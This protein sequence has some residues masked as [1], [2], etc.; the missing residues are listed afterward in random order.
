ME[1][2]N[3]PQGFLPLHTLSIICHFLCNLC[4]INWTELNST[5]DYTINT[6][7]LWNNSNTKTLFIKYISCKIIQHVSHNMIFICKWN[8][9]AESKPEH[10]VFIYFLLYLRNTLFAPGIHVNVC[11]CPFSLSWVTGIA[12]QRLK[13]Q[14]YS[15]TQPVSNIWFREVRKANVHLRKETKDRHGLQGLRWLTLCIIVYLTQL[16]S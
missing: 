15:V 4:K 13:Q 9:L 2:L 8:I 5:N 11:L 16:Y 10:W 1:A 14:L 12:K 3:K 6:K 7:I